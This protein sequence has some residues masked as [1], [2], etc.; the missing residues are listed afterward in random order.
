MYRAANS[1]VP[2]A[3][4]APRVAL[5]C[6]SLRWVAHCTDSRRVVPARAGAE[7]DQ[8]RSCAPDT[9]RRTA[10]PSGRPQRGRARPRARSRPRPSRRARR[11]SGPRATGADPRERGR[12][13]RHRACRT[14]SPGRTTPGARGTGRSGLVPHPLD[15]CDPAQHEQDVDR[16]RRRPPG[17]RCGPHRRSSRTG[18]PG[19]STQLTTQERCRLLGTPLRS[20]GCSGSLI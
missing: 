12:R 8:A 13:A 2:H 1:F 7:Q 6:S 10:W 16:T 19:R 3:A 14:P 5:P 4:P 11:P 18:S 9:S 17:T 15:V 20:A